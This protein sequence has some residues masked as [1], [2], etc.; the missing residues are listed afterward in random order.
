LKDNRLVPNGF[1]TSHFTYDTVKMAGLV[2]DDANFNYTGGVEGSGS[3]LIEYRIP[4]NGYT[5]AFEVTANLMY[6][7]VPPKWN[8]E[9]FA[10]DLPVINE[11]EEMYWESG[12]DP[13]LIDS[14]SWESVIV[15]VDEHVSSV[16]VFP[17]PTWTGAVTVNCTAPLTLTL[18]DATGRKM[19]DVSFNTGSNTI[20]L[21]SAGTYFLSSLSLENP[22]LMRILAL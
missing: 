9:L 20:Q 14:Q 22:V 6:Q 18:L 2:L 13:V 4:L 12:P 5:G 7:S 17:N 1:T 21:P 8:D 10:V 15:G 19:R 11:F 16:S 3:D